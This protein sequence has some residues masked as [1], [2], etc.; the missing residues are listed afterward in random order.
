MEELDPVLQHALAETYKV[1]VVPTSSVNMQK[2]YVQSR[3]APPLP[4]NPLKGCHKIYLDMG[5]NIGEKLF[6]LF[7]PLDGPRHRQKPFDWFF[8][9]GKANRSD[10][11]AVGFE[12]NY[13]LTSR[14]R[15]VQTRFQRRGHRVYIFKAAVALDSGTATLFSDTE[16]DSF[17]AWGK[18]L[19]KYDG[20]MGRRNMATVPTVSLPWLLHSFLA[21]APGTSPPRIMAKMDV[22]GAEYNLISVAWPLM[23]RSIDML[24]LERH[25]RFFKNSWRWK[26]KLQRTEA[27][28]EGVVRIKRLDDALAQ[29]KA[30]RS[31]RTTVTLMHSWEGRGYPDELAVA[32]NS[33]TYA[34]AFGGLGTLATSRSFRMG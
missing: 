28:G 17:H 10:V 2:A 16:Q 6:V 33:T 34:T 14:L 21:P 25:D 4:T 32:R 19:V 8:G 22:E 30:S 27:S 13:N 24:M 15:R 11:C 7:D 29:M 9:T 31:C 20:R 23:C 18:T 26:N 12:P 5:L 3:G 1:D